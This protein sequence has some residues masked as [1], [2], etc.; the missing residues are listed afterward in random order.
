MSD[1]T[2]LI[3]SERAHEL[4]SKPG[5]PRRHL[6]KSRVTTYARDMRAKKWRHEVA[7]P[8]VLDRKSGAVLDG[9]HRLN[10]VI[11]AGD[12]YKL[13][14]AI[15]ETDAAATLVMDVGR[16]RSLQNTLEI[17]GHEHAKY[18]SAFLNTAC[19]WA[20]NERAGSR[21]SRAEQIAWLESNPNT[22]AAAAFAHQ[23]HRNK[24]HHKRVWVPTGT[25]A[26]L[27]DIAEYAHGGDTVAE[28]VEVIE[29][30]RGESGSML[31]R[32]TT[33]MLDAKNPKTRTKVTADQLGYM[34]ARVYVSWL[35]GVDLEKLFTRRNAVM[36][37]PGFGEWMG[38]N[39]D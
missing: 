4:L 28:F 19:L 15:V 23:H 30:D 32:L 7:P 37:L 14:T 22:D 36:E 24:T 12:N 9:Q 1:T 39:W 5:A 29:F 27:W 25:C 2:T 6:S 11:L 26:T 17:L 16:P 3:T 20:K 8:I 34:L 21:M 31:Q 33:L 38:A 35:D 18:K 13:R 10:A